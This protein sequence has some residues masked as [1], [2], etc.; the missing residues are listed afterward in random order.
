MFKGEPS[1]QDLDNSGYHQKTWVIRQSMSIC[2]F[3]THERTESL[4]QC[5][6]HQATERYCT[7]MH[8][9]TNTLHWTVNT[10]FEYTLFLQDCKLTIRNTLFYFITFAQQC[11]LKIFQTGIHFISS[12]NCKDT[13]RIH[14]ISSTEFKYS[15]LNTFFYFI[16][17][18]QQCISKENCSIKR[19]CSILNRQCDRQ[20]RRS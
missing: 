12:L 11:I 7:V 3:V 8:F 20:L 13:F 5:V 16:T 9:W 1:A 17:F 4:R 2:T 19:V 6:Y 18:A 10:L 15:I 14:S